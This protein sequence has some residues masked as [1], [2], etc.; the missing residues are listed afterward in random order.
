MRILFSTYP[1]H[2]HLLPLLPLAKAADRAGHQVVVASGREGGDEAARRG[3]PTWNVGPSRAE[4]DAAFR[5]TVGDLGDIPPERRIPTIVAGIF[6]AAAFRRAERLVPRAVAWEPDVVVHSIS[7][8]AGAIAAARSGA[9]HIVHGLGPLAPEAWTW[10]GS[11]F[12]ELCRTWDVPDLATTV[13]D[14]PYI[15]TCPR[16]LQDDAV[17]AFR[18]RVALRPSAGE[19]LVGERLPWDEATLR[20]LPHERTIH[21]TLGTIFNDL[22]GVF[23]TVLTGLRALPVNVIVAVGPGSDPKRLGPQPPNVLVTDFVSH[24]LL[25]PHCD[26]IITQGGAG[27]I[28][29]ALCHGLPHLILPQGA[30]QF[31]NATTAERAGVALQLPPPA[32]TPEAVTSVVGRLL[33]DDGIAANARRIQA[34]IGTMPTADEVLA[35]LLPSPADE[36]LVAGT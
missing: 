20:A 10:F 13:L 29:A 2:G 3:L 1:A 22:T 7:E 5:E 30:D 4:A 12:E 25:L 18:N 17:A 6:G 32:L 33:D 34:E 16:S 23:D 28:L 11:V 36:V 15:D 8:L 9:K 26:A 35:G 14:A 21:L 19:V 27:T 24:T 31:I